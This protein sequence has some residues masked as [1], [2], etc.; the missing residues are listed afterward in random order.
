MCCRRK[1]CIWDVWNATGILR[2]PGEWVLYVCS[3]VPVLVFSFSL[4]WFFFNFVNMV[5]QVKIRL[6]ACGCVVAGKERQIKGEVRGDECKTQS[7]AHVRGIYTSIHRQWTTICA[8]VSYL[9]YWCLFITKFLIIFLSHYIFVFFCL[10]LWLAL[11]FI[12]CA[13]A[14]FS[15]QRLLEITRYDYKYKMLWLFGFVVAVLF[16]FL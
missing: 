1:T 9:H 16:L 15:T 11:R 10:L 6:A 8:C 2:G 12:W 14:H 3:C 5:Y 4:T 13:R 7:H